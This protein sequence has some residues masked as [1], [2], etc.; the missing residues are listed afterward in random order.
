MSYRN[1]VI[2]LLGLLFSCSKAPQEIAANIDNGLQPL[3]I[4]KAGD[5]PL[6]FELGE[7]GP[8]LINSPAEASLVPFT[9]WPLTRHIRAILSQGEELVFGVNRDGFLRAVP[10]GSD[11]DIGLYRIADAAYWGQ[12]S[13]G[14]LFWFDKKAAALL[15]QDDFFIDSSVPLPSPRTW[16]MENAPVPQELEIPAFDTLNAKD[17]WNIDALR[18]GSDGFWYYRGVN[19]NSGESV[20]PKIAYLKTADLT[21]QGEAVSISAF[22]NS[23]LPE[24][25]SVAPVLLRLVLEK[26]FDAGGLSAQVIS[27]VYPP[28][29]GTPLDF[30]PFRRFAGRGGNSSAETGA[31]SEI[32]AYYR[33]GGTGNPICALAALGDGR[34]FFAFTGAAD[35]EVFDLQNVK[36]K[37]LV[38]PALPEGFVYTGLALSADTL[39][40]AW[41]EQ[42]GYSI[43]ASGFMVIKPF[44]LY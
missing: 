26:A 25:L 42:Q 21:R 6:W 35:D 33:C 1:V 12:Y 44:G 39:F 27:S 22:Q 20:P 19:K 36:I 2:L 31:S 23:V 29:S 32:F 14:A 9:P 30:L 7:N 41:E 18:Q 10:W 24:P 37:N 13:L 17:G 3:A 40:L 15:Y 8:A 5:N 34:L 38:L 11:A 28:D 4:L 43:G 16:G